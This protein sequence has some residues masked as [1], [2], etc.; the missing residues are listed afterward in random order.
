MIAALAAFL[1]SLPLRIR[2][3]PISAGCVALAIGL[4]IANYFLW[5]RRQEITRRHE[6]VRRNG[7]FMLRALATRARV[8]SELTALRS[9][10]DQ[11]ESNLLDEASMEVNLGYF[12]RL[13][14][15]T[16]V[17]LVRL[18]QLGSTPAA[19]GS[20]FKA[21]PFS[22][23]ITGSYRNSMSFLRALETGSRLVRIR[24][25]SFERANEGNS[26]L[27]LDLTVDVLTKA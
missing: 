24:Q 22:M 25:S 16:R 9:A 18:N 19:P 8:D 15:M 3:R 21:V 13:E 27:I 6:E 4:G 10:M 1:A 7:E 11:I 20:P 12:Y 5:E 2:H 26:D 14:R 17:R 23:Q